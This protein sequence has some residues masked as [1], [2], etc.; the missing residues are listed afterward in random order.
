M[1][2]IDAKL[3]EPAVT[4]EWRQADRKTKW[5]VLLEV[6]LAYMQA[7]G[8]DRAVLFPAELAWGQYAYSI[9][10]ERFRWVPMVG[11]PAY[12]GIDP[13]TPAIDRTISELRKSPGVAG[14]RMLGGLTSNWL[15][16]FI[17]AIEVCARVGLPVFL[18]ATGHLSA[19][20]KIAQRHPGVTIILDNLG[21]PQTPGEQ[22][23]S[24]PFKS[25]PQILELAAY[26]DI[27]LLLSSA[28]SLSERPYPYP[29]VW[30]KLRQIV[31]TFGPQRLMW[32][33]DLSRFIGRCGF[34]VRIPGAE[35]DY[36]PNHSYAESLFFLRENQQLSAAEK[37]WIL[38]GTARRLLGWPA[39]D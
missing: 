5:D 1:M 19:A 37:A 8:V 25:L 28:V 12:G 4:F 30:P 39:P 35:G 38:G 29:D 21:L 11:N 16:Q 9:Q 7:V 2:L 6:Q 10:P 23:E 34:Q 31:D 24:P 15:D 13:L 3:H 36:A 17:P 18:T 33:S 26:P 22:P 27:A 32:G 14:I 20:A